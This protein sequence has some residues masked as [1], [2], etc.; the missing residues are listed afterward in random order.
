MLALIVCRTDQTSGILLSLIVF[1]YVSKA[2]QNK[3]LVLI[4]RLL[5]PIRP[6]MLLMA[7]RGRSCQ[8]PLNILTLTASTRRRALVVFLTSHGQIVV[9][10]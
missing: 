2:M 1:D 5:I 7:R 6:A 9:R 4:H 10:A 8:T 3:L